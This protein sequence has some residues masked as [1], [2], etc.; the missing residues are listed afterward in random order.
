M[1]AQAQDAFLY[2]GEYYSF[3]EGDERKLLKP[4]N[5]GMT[6]ESTLSSCWRGFHSVYEITSEGM[7]LT[8]MTIMDVK[9]GI[10]QPIQSIM[11]ETDFYMYCRKPGE[12]DWR[13]AGDKIDDGKEERLRAQGYEIKLEPFSSTYKKLRVPV[14]YSGDLILGREF[15]QEMYIHMGY[16]RAVAYKKLLYLEFTNGLLNKLV[17]LSEANAIQR[18]KC[19]KNPEEYKHHAIMKFFIKELLNINKKFESN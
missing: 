2:Q 12:E 11:P 19:I 18:E 3:I 9:D 4:Q 14:Q 17:D 15:I 7:F 16:Q 6:P 10:F 8:E 13:G 1:T 5:F